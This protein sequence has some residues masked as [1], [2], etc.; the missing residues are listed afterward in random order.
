[1]TPHIL[2]IILIAFCVFFSVC[3]L[4]CI[5]SHKGWRKGNHFRGYWERR[6]K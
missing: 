1:M 4:V 2:S 6:A 5:F 3:I